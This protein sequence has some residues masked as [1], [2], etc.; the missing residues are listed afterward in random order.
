MKFLNLIIVC[1]FLLQCQSFQCHDFRDCHWKLKV[2][3][4]FFKLKVVPQ[5]TEETKNQ[6]ESLKDVKTR[7]SLIQSSVDESTYDVSSEIFELLSLMTNTNKEFL[8]V[9]QQLLNQYFKIYI[10]NNLNKK[11]NLHF[12][13]KD[14][15]KLI[16]RM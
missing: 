2:K 15:V 13:T 6:I 11:F 9:F 10:E 7:K 12:D 3:Y 1:N 16:I 5:L 4:R 8:F 14:I